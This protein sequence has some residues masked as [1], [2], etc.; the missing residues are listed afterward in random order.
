MP[1]PWIQAPKGALLPGGQ[2]VF[3][4]IGLPRPM[5]C[6]VALHERGPFGIPDN[7]WRLAPRVS[8]CPVVGAQFHGL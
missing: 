7:F 1:G 6:W 8:R 3:G 4:S 5:V 2:L